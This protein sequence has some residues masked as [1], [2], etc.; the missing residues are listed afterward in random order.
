[1]A[2]GSE[3]TGGWA[4]DLREG[5]GELVAPAGCSYRGDWVKGRR[6]GHGR[7]VM[8]KGGGASEEKIYEGG[9]A[10]D[11]FHG[12]GV[13]ACEG[14]RKYDGQWNHGKRHG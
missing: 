3:Y 12:K 8:R 5:F 10:N 7:A 11:E 1:M 13:L 9:W 2:D 4:N 14:N 6:H